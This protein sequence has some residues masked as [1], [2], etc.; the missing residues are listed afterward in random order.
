MYLK[1]KQDGSAKGRGYADGR[2]QRLYIPKTETS[3][4]T[5]SL[6]GIMLTCKIVEAFEQRDVATVDIPGA[7]LQT[8]MPE[9]EED[10][11]VVLDGRMAELLAKIEPETYQNYVHHRRGQAYIYC[12]INVA[13]HGN[14]KAALFFGGS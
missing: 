12:E 9:D 4:P 1:E 8:K 2:P 7:I 11:H 3:L 14:L 5:A 10:V 6:L 13:L